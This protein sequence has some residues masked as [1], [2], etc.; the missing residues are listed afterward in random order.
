[1]QACLADPDFHNSPG[2]TR[3]SSTNLE[4]DFLPIHGVSG[5]IRLYRVN[6]EY[7][8]LYEGRVQD[9]RDLNEPPSNIVGGLGVFS[10]FAS[11]EEI[12]TARLSS[13]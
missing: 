4:Y 5:R 6:Q 3:D 9:S 2:R 1:M 13:E 11:S 12:F 10:A 7:A 8:D